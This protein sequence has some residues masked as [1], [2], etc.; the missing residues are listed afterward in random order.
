MRWNS[1]NGVS[2]R[3]VVHVD[4]EIQEIVPGFLENRCEDIASMLQALDR[5]DYET[6]RI[7]GHSMKGAGSGYGF[8]GITDLGQSIEYAA[9]KENDED[10]R[11]LMIELSTYL[12]SLDVV[13]E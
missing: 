8:D 3:I 6:I 1:N 13:Y 12:Y 7:L 2:G 5:R 11:K 4:T 10:I 9:E